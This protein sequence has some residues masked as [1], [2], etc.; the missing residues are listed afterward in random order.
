MST[1]SPIRSIPLAEPAQALEGAS[2][3][4]GFRD[5]LEGAIG[6][7]EN[8]RRE[9]SQAVESFLAGEGGELHTT[10]LATQRA[11]LALELFLQTRNKVV[12]AYQEIMRMQ[13]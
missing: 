2:K 8:R 10:V 7:V 5:L 6:S 9:A 11:E 12:Q 3:Q 4:A 13:V 1:V